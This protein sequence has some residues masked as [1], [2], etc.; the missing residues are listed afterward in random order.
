MSAFH[1]T[2]CSTCGRKLHTTFFCQD[3]GQACCSLDCY[4]RHQSGHGD[5]KETAQGG[6][7]VEASPARLETAR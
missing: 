5:A 2:C 6:Q 3:C 1:Y 4:C 7:E